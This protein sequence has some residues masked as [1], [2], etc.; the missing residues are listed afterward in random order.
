VN[1]QEEEVLRVMNLLQE[2][3]RWKGGESKEFIYLSRQT[4]YQCRSQ[5]FILTL[6]IENEIVSTPR[7]LACVKS[8]SMKIF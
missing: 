5:F 6:F 3:R 4:I 1:P 2:K 8:N 7:S